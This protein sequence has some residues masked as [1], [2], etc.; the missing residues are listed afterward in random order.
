MVKSY[1]S[2]KIEIRSSN[3]HGKGMFATK[4]IKIGE[5]VFIHGGHILTRDEMFYSEVIGSYLPLDDNFYIGA[6]NNK[7][8]KRVKLWVN[9]SCNPNCVIRGEITFIAMKNIQVGEELNIDYAT[10]DNEEYKFTCTC[11]SVT[12]RKVITGFDWKLPEI[13]KKYQGFFAR[14]LSDKMNAQAR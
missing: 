11:A 3:I 4:L 2:P 6:K 5:I 14:Y 1:I 7:E 8:E 13:Q 10:V 9:H 12:C